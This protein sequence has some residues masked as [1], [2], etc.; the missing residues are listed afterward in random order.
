MSRHSRYY[1]IIIG[2]GKFKKGLIATRKKGEKGLDFHICWLNK[3]LPSGAWFEP[4]DIDGIEAT[5]HFVDR[6]VL[7]ATVDFLNRIMKDWK[8]EDNDEN[9][10]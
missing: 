8:E 4:E 5:I 6:N 7:K 2:G 1:P 9:H 10:D 3:E